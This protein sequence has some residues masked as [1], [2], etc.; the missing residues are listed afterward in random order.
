APSDVLPPTARA[1]SAT[2][3]EVNWTAPTQPNGVLKLFLL[4]CS[5]AKQGCAPKS[6]AT[7]DNETTATRVGNLN[8]YIEYQCSVVFSTIA[9]VGQNSTEC[10]VKSALSSPNR[11]MPSGFRGAERATVPFQSYLLKSNMTSHSD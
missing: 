9:A 8:P 3:I 11:T 1:I 6:V 4:T 5:K 2:E 7:R 10:E